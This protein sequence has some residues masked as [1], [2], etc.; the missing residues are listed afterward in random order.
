MTIREALGW[1]KGRGDNKIY[2]EIDCLQVVQVIQLEGMGNKL[3]RLRSLHIKDETKLRKEGII[4]RNNNTTVYNGKY[5]DEAVAIKV[6]QKE[7]GTNV[8]SHRRRKFVREV[9]ALSAA[10][11]DNI[12]KFIGFSL[13]PAMTL[14]TEIMK[15]GSLQKHLWNIRPSTLDRK[16]ALVMA[17]EISR[18]MA[19]LHENGIIHRDLNPNNIFLSESK[20]SVKLGDFG[21]CREGLEGDFSADVG[22]FRW[23]APE[24]YSRE[25]HGITRL[26]TRY[27]HKVDVYSFA[28]VLWELLTNKTPF[29]GK[30]NNAIAQAVINNERPS[31]DEEHIP[32]D[33]HHLLESCWSNDPLQRPEFS[34]I[35]ELL[36]ELLNRIDPG[37]DR[38]ESSFIA[39]RPETLWGKA[40]KSVKLGDFGLC[41]EGLQ[42]NSR[43]IAPE[44]YSREQ[45]E[46]TS[47]TT[48]YNHKVD[49]YSFAIVLWELL[50]SKTPF[51][52]KDFKTIAQ[53]VIKNQR[54]RLNEDELPEY[55]VFLMEP[56]FD[57][58]ESSFNVVD[59]TALVSATVPTITLFGTTITVPTC[60]DN[61][62]DSILLCCDYIHPSLCC[63]CPSCETIQ[64][65]LC[66]CCPSCETIQ[67]RL[68]CCCPSCETIQTRLC[69]CCPSCDSI[70]KILCC[71][72]HNW[73]AIQATLCAC[74]PSR[75]SIQTTLAS[76]CPTC[77][78]IQTRLHTCY[79]SIEN[80]CCCCPTWDCV[81]TLLTCWWPTRDCIL[82]WMGSCF[83]GC[84][85]IFTKLGSC[86]GL[87]G[88]EGDRTAEPNRARLR[89]D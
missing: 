30:D 50:T 73:Y 28:I 65:S 62:Y 83:A 45:H 39:S 7:R 20:K 25:Q 75:G 60:L 57:T 51:Q 74:C 36:E 12:V 29:Q 9:R 11:H 22:S 72:C 81:F 43:W 86:L 52:G 24:V 16:E 41:R 87:S 78:S 21:L 69:C 68:C 59:Q 88:T 3:S 58:V 33:I 1:V 76:C 63:C 31:L 4:S 56:S 10:K 66:G 82:E 89:Q 54:P 15:G 70:C 47:I 61:C 38:I 55:I 42:G 64:T 67:T 71:F 79:E 14:V 85:S 44:V 17:L 6:I 49:A 23:M 84:D 18:A 26:T 2:V 77:E 37:W 40:K 48:R 13:E 35:S 32:D 19:Y 46:I 27:N 5:M 80:I 8:C 34:H 53:A